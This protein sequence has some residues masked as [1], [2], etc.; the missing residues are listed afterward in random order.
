VL[1]STL[2]V[3]NPAIDPKKEQKNNFKKA[4]TKGKENKERDEITT[5]T[6]KL[7]GLEKKFTL[8]FFKPTHKEENQQEGKKKKK[9]KKAGKDQQLTSKARPHKKPNREERDNTVFSLQF[10]DIEKLMFFFQT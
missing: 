1:S 7:Q 5:S 9:T 3:F 4:L 2:E 8:K 10:C 6:M